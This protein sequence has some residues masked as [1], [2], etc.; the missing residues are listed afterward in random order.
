M[1][2]KCFS[3]V[4]EMYDSCSYYVGTVAMSA[5]TLVACGSFAGAAEG[6][7]VPVNITSSNIQWSE[8]PGKIISELTTPLV[9]A[10]GI[11]LSLLVI[12]W[13]VRMFKTGARA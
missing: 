3:V 7:P 1:F 10:I 12:I 8:L 13:A 4:S 2:K 5:L 6:D 11:G 9:T